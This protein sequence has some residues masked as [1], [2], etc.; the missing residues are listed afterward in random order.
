MT[1]SS[2]SRKPRPAPTGKNSL[3]TRRSRKV[4]PPK[5][6]WR[7]AV[8]RLRTTVWV[9]FGCLALGIA[10]FAILYSVVQVPTAANDAAVAQVTTIYYSDGKAVL[11]RVGTENREIVDLKVVPK[12]VRDAVVAAEDRSFYT[13]HGVTLTGI[14][15]AIIANFRGGGVKQGG[16]GITQQFVKN[17]YLTQERTLTRKLKEV[18]IAIKV[19]RATSK[20][21]ILEGYLNTIWFGRG[22]SGIQ[23]A[24][25]A[26][27]NKPVDKLSVAEGAVL[28]A[29]IKG[30]ALYDPTNHPQAAH[31]RWKYV[32]DGMVADQ[33]L[34]QAQADALKYPKVYPPKGSSTAAQG[35]ER[36]IENAV[37]DEL[38]AKGVSEQD[39]QTGGLKVV[40]TIDKPAQ[41]AAD[42]AEADVFVKGVAKATKKPVS[43]LI[44]IEP[45]TGRVKAMYAGDNY[46]DGGCDDKQ[47]NCL[48]LATQIKRQPGSSFKPFVLSTA[49]DQGTIKITDRRDGPTEAKLEDGTPVRNDGDSESCNNC[50]LVD[51]MAQSI[52]TI[53]EPLAERI[54]PDKVAEHA[55]VLGIPDTVP[56]KDASGTGPSIAL[57]AYDVHP[58]DMASAYGTFA[59]G[60]VRSTPYFVETVKDNSGTSVYKAKPDTSQVLDAGV[61]ADVT[62]ALQAVVTAPKA[63]GHA[64]ALDGGRPVAGKTGTTQESRNAWFVGYT[65]Q[66]VTAVW[67]GNVDNTSTVGQIPGLDKGLYGGTLP[68]QTFKAYMDGALKGQPVKQFPAPRQVEPSVT[69]SASVSSTSASATPTVSATPT[70]SATPTVTATPTL[71]VTTTPT[72]SI[73]DVPTASPTPTP[74]P[75]TSAPPPS[76]PASAPAAPGGGTATG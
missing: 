40:T 33:A 70:A 56:L 73:T 23:A 46:A 53:Y 71:T 9:L 66:L 57:G 50:T 32:I 76:G 45:G 1:D 3:I 22:A 65:P 68:A 30:P 48:N 6:G 38:T 62:A 49:L 21:Q 26:Y 13:S 29:S 8:P 42:A 67:M 59:S 2:P 11:A 43:S 24:S 18:V 19:D 47:A 61:A 39:V 7:H 25:R 4:L 69:P 72:T 12:H 75:G 20:D 10:A 31:D 58:V 55:H 41:D 34:T 14:P 17:T 74:P 16:S 60:G 5:T 63:T 36:F 51:A 28:A 37:L 27:F 15:R 54:G 35:P 52:N 64:A 44:S